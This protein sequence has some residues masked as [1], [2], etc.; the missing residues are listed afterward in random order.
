MLHR[1]ERKRKSPDNEPHEMQQRKKPRLIHEIPTEIWL[2]IIAKVFEN[3]LTEEDMWKTRL[4]KLVQKAV[5][6]SHVMARRPLI[7]VALQ[8]D[9]QKQLED[10]TQKRLKDSD[11]S[12]SEDTLLKSEAPSLIQRQKEVY[13][14]AFSLTASCTALHECMSHNDI[15]KSILFLTIGGRAWYDSNQGAIDNEFQGSFKQACR[16]LMTFGLSTPLATSSIHI[17]DSTSNLVVDQGE[18]TYLK[19]GTGI[20]SYNLN[21]K[22]TSV[23]KEMQVVI[24]CSKLQKFGHNIVFQKDHK[25]VVYNREHDSINTTAASNYLAF[26][27]YKDNVFAWGNGGY[28][29]KALKSDV[30]SHKL[31]A[32]ALGK[33][34]ILRDLPIIL[35]FTGTGPIEIF[36]YLEIGKGI[37]YS[38]TI[39]IRHMITKRFSDKLVSEISSRIFYLDPLTKKIAEYNPITFERLSEIPVNNPIL[40]KCNFDTDLTKRK[41]FT[42]LGNFAIVKSRAKSGTNWFIFDIRGGKQVNTWNMPKKTYA[43]VGSNL[44]Y[45]DGGTIHRYTLLPEEDDEEMALESEKILYSQP[46]KDNQDLTKSAEIMARFISVE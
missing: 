43:F 33:P 1:V 26:G 32:Q 34:I 25:F 31:D 21:T 28:K 3:Y 38:T 10:A 30:S 41:P 17:K 45:S 40:T 9:P 19:Y 22:V 24:E 13:N 14:L 20:C 5:K 44:M 27:S 16:F 12:V 42:V 37:Y 36:S 46:A 2:P 35:W 39:L 4:S 29:L 7:N 15:W 18:V 6:S 11:S 23:V 8:D